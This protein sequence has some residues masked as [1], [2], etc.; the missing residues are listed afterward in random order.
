ML[1]ASGVGGWYSRQPPTDVLEF[2]RAAGE[3]CDDRT[4]ALRCPKEVG[5]GMNTLGKLVGSHTGF[6]V[7]QGTLI[8]VCRRCVDSWT[9]VDIDPPTITTSLNDPSC[10]L[11][12]QPSRMYQVGITDYP[13]RQRPLEGGQGI[14]QRTP[15][16]LVVG[17]EPGCFASSLE[18][19]PQ[20]FGPVGKD[21]GRPG[22]CRCGHGPLKITQPVDAQ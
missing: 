11:S 2:G 5:Y 21:L 18:K 19:A 14:M 1:D 22:H 4:D 12:A 3:Q 10:R 9:H 20:R 6:V 15:Y 17:D 8:G 16:L 13:N 7:E